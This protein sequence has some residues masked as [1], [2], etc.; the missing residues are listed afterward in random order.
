M[1]TT[2]TTDL[3]ILGEHD[4]AKAP[5]INSTAKKWERVCRQSSWHEYFFSFL[6]CEIFLRTQHAVNKMQCPSQT[7]SPRLW[8]VLEEGVISACSHSLACG[9]TSLVG[10]QTWTFW[11]RVCLAQCSSWR[12]V[13]EQHP[14]F[15]QQTNNL[16]LTLLAAKPAALAGCPSSLG[17]LRALPGEGSGG[18]LSTKSAAWEKRGGGGGD[19]GPLESLQQGSGSKVDPRGTRIYQSGWSWSSVIWAGISSWKESR[20]GLAN[21]SCTEICNET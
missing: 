6:S 16:I 17:G 21:N 9:R 5:L 18:E 13:D 20:G 2:K 4:G 8:L 3:F 10:R 1:E 7:N 19:G 15:S 11:I 12:D 14:C